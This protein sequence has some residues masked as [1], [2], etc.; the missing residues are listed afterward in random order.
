MLFPE[1]NLDV[2]EILPNKQI[3]DL[4]FKIIMTTPV[5]IK[6]HAFNTNGKFYFEQCVGEGCELCITAKT[7]SKHETDSS[8]LNKYRVLT[9]YHLPVIVESNNNGIFPGVYV[10]SFGRLINTAFTNFIY[11]FKKFQYNPEKTSLNF[12]NSYGLLDD[13]HKW[14][15]YNDC[16]FTVG[17]GK[18]KYTVRELSHM[19]G[20]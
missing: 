16:Y 15:D 13:L 10:F 6:S 14:P 11:N 1:L 19:N 7:L 18:R 20:V 3:K 4:T 12:T 8:K 9:R 5:Q 2:K 17:N